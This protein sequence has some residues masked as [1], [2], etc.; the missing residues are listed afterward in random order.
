MFHKT[1]LFAA[2]KA[3]IEPKITPILNILLAILMCFHGPISNHS[4]Q[5]EITLL[6]ANNLLHWH[7]P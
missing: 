2:G 3:V 6:I 5:N 4:L 7:R 1:P